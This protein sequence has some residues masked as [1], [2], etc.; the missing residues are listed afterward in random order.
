MSPKASKNEPAVEVEVEYTLADALHTLTASNRPTARPYGYRIESAC[1]AAMS[2]VITFYGLELGS[3]SE[4]I[5]DL[6]ARGAA[7]LAAERA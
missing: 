5:R 7:A 6:V 4:A 3:E 1:N 2:D